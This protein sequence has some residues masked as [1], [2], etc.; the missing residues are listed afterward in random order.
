[1]Y[2]QA[3]GVGWSLG[4][5][6]SSGRG[7]QGRLGNLLSCQVGQRWLRRLSSRTRDIVPDAVR[8]AAVCPATDRCRS[9]C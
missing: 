3:A 8:D 5:P 4:A 6:A 7:V 2:L 9:A 1:M